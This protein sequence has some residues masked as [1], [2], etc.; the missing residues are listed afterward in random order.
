MAPPNPLAAGRPTDLAVSGAREARALARRILRSWENDSPTGSAHTLDAKRRDLRAFAHWARLEG[1]GEDLRIAAVERLLFGGFA[2]THEAVRAWLSWMAEK[3]PADGRL[4]PRRAPATRA[5]RLASLRGLVRIAQEH[6]LP[7]GLQ[8]KGPRVR[9]YRDATGP[10]AWRVY[11][12][13]AELAHEGSDAA[14]RDGAILHLLFVLG[15]RRQ[16]VAD[17]ALEDLRDDGVIWLR[18]KGEEEPIVKVA[19]PATRAALA[20]WTAARGRWPGPL[21]TGTRRHERRQGLSAGQIYR[22]CYKYDLGNPH[23]LRHSSATKLAREGR[24]VWEI[25][26][27]LGHASPTTSQHYVDGVEDTPGQVSAYLAE[28]LE[29]LYDEDHG[30]TNGGGD[31]GSGASGGAGGLRGGPDPPDGP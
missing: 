23:G 11:A 22:I 24:S 7:W 20:R 31:G 21:M 6:G 26:A 30:D 10:E 12:V 27:H 15:L 18:V 25:Q 8:I 14:A 16:S 5:R 13:I 1:D 2:G 3:I 19:P 29:G 28:Q 17:L 9:R 4:R